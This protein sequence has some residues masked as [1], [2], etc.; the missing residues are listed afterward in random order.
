MAILKL[1]YI[2]PFYV[3]RFCVA[4]EKVMD[5]LYKISGKYRK[6]EKNKP[7]NLQTTVQHYFVA[8]NLF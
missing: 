2:L 3:R 5:C 4:R 1:L 8:A 6:L 7:K